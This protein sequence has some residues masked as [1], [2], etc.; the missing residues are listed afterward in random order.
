MNKAQALAVLSEMK[1][2]TAKV[3]KSL[4][5]S[6]APNASA[7]WQRRADALDFAIRELSK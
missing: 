5:K 4:S 1:S 2:C 3:L 7:Q 6:L